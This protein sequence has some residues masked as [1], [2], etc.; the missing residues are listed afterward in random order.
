MWSKQM[1]KS[2]IRIVVNQL[3]FYWS[4]FQKSLTWNK[5]ITTLFPNNVWQCQL[6]RRRVRII[7][8][9]QKLQFR[10]IINI[11]HIGSKLRPIQMPFNDVR[12]KVKLTILHICNVWW[13]DRVILQLEHLNIVKKMWKIKDK[14]RNW[15]SILMFYTSI[16]K[17]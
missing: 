1:K 17:Y 14:V 6:Q 9:Q 7:K 4:S 15:I 2:L 12:C 5:Y 13:N 10:L 8:Q 16:R 11:T 3:P